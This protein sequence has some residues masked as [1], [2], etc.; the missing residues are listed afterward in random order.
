MVRP[1]IAHG[2]LSGM[3]RGVLFADRTDAGWRLARRLAQLRPFDVVVVGLPRGGV[4]VA[5]EVAQALDAPL[6]VILVRKLN[7][8]VLSAAGIT[9]EQLAQVEAQERAEL[10]RRA[11]VLR[12][13]HPVVPLDGR[14][15]VVVDDGVATG[16]TARVACMLA[17][18]HGAARVVLAV[19]VAPPG[20]ERRFEDV[21]DELVCVATPPSFGSI[22]AYY[23][24]FAQASDEDVVAC[25]ARAASRPQP[26]RP[27]EGGSRS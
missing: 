22:G 26:G 5:Q 11:Q 23:A 14:V 9:E 24:D 6:D 13:G 19:P 4:I 20:W 3:R 1:K 2:V 8:A 18:A 27:T 15:V 25:L 17:R 10:E 21:A 7:V 16:A 12:A